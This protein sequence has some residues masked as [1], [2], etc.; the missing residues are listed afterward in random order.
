MQR[1]VFDRIGLPAM[2]ALEHVQVRRIAAIGARLAAAIT[3]SAGL[4]LVRLQ[5]RLRVRLHGGARMPRP[6]RHC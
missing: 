1:R 5:L 3:G 6:R 2:H 4:E